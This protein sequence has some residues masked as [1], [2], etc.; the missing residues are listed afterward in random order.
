MQDNIPLSDIRQNYSK[1]KLDIDDLASDPI[2]MSQFWLQEALQNPSVQEPTAF[3]LATVSPEGQP[4][5]RVLLLKEINDAGFIFFT[6]YK[7]RKAAHID[8]NPQVAILFFWSALERQIRVEG[9]IEKIDPEQ[10]TRYFQSRPR[11]SQISAWASPQSEIIPDRTM[12]DDRALDIASTYKD[13]DP[14]PKP[15]QWGGYIIKPHYFEFW[16]GR[17]DRLHDR[18]TYSRQGETWEIHRLAP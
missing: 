16:Q 1:L 6:N 17:A 18:L 14:L 5:A 11:G 9:N 8:T 15:P 3:T 12:L 10:A 4:A 7:S 2:Q 13:R